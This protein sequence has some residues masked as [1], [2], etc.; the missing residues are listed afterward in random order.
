MDNSILRDFLIQAT[1]T[2]N[3]Q[4]P[5][6]N[7]PCGAVGCKMCPIWTVS[8]EFTSHTTGWEFKKNFAASYLQVLQYDLSNNL[9]EL[10]PTICG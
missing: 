2:T 4:E 9:Q 1:L 6:G 5:T 10:W 3:N 8:D 7:H